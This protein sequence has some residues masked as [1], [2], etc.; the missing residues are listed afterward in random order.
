MA[1]GSPASPDA[2]FARP[3]QPHV[4]PASV[5]SQQSTDCRRVR[6]LQRSECLLCCRYPPPLPDSCLEVLRPRVEG[7][8]GRPFET[9]KLRALWH[10]RRVAEY[11]RGWETAPR[12]GLRP[13]PDLLRGPRRKR[14]RG[15][16]K[17]SRRPESGR[18]EGVG[19]PLAG[20][21]RSETFD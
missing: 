9:A 3:R 1:S 19:I 11:F 8:A 15:V 2:P 12:Y 7:P 6:Q 10:T 5:L 13:Y 4:H 21:I 20:L 18:V 17:S 14:S 16:R